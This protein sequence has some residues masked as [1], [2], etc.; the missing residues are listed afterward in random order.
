[1]LVMHSENW[2]D[3]RFVL[4]VAEA[5]TVSGAARTLGV[6]H[7]T[8]LRRVAAFEARHEVAVFERGPGGYAVPRDR[9]RVIEAAR[10]A[11]SG[12]LA[13]ARILAGARVPLSGAVRVTSTDTF[14]VAVLPVLV[15]GILAEAPTLR[16]D[17][18]SSNAHSDLARLEAEIAVRPA[19][20]LPEELFGEEAGQLGFAIYAPAADPGIRPWLRLSGVLSRVAAASWIAEACAEDPVAGA[21]DSFVTLREMV[22]AGQGRAVLPCVLGDGDPR[23]ARR[24]ADMP[25]FQVPIWVASHTDLADSPRVSAVRAR[26]VTGLRGMADRLK[27]R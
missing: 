25:P 3:L 2:D 8:V 4:A 16:I 21:G 7:A 27:G 12:H 22:A 14:C 24:E 23:L 17:V 26:L 9:A 1:M 15:A 11:A 10:E 6:N 5:G 19:A 18:L 13:V 20:R